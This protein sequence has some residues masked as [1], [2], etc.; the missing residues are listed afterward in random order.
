MCTLETWKGLISINNIKNN[1][2]VNDNHK[3]YYT[4]TTTT[5]IKKF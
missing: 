1:E 2:I 4:T 5:T 3:A